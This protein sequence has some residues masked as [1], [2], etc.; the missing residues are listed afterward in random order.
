MTESGRR[1]GVK[2]GAGGREGVLTKKVYSRYTVHLISP[3]CYTEIPLI[4]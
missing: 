1:E 3:Q 2:T 4:S